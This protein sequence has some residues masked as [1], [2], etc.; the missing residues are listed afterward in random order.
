MS[1]F[2]YGYSKLKYADNYKY[3]GFTF[4]IDQKD[5]KDMI[6]LLINIYTKSNRLLRLF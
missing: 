3:V 4:S 2:I 5:D 1:Y 6:H